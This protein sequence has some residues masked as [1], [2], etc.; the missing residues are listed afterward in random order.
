[1]TEMKIWKTVMEIK[2][3]LEY[4]SPTSNKTKINEEKW[5]RNGTHNIYR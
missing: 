1:M 5:F 3:C 2:S 4:Y